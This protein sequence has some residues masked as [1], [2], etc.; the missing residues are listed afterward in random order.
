MALLD[1]PS[2]LL[3]RISAYLSERDLDCFTRACTT[4]Q[5]LL[6]DNKPLYAAC[7]AL[8]FK[9]SRAARLSAGLTRSVYRPD[10][11]AKQVDPFSMAR[12]V[13]PGL[14]PGEVLCRPQ[15]AEWVLWC[16]GLRGDG[17]AMDWVL[18]M[19][20]ASMAYILRHTNAANYDRCVTQEWHS[21]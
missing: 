10:G 13:H 4:T 3:V 21:S 14:T 6:R 7:R 5:R 11:E 20:D 16:A 19:S 12:S 17:R 9:T 18:G 1:L 8:G 15:L 2:P